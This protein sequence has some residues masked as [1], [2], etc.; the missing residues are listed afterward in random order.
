[1]EAKAE[2]SDSDE[3]YK[4]LNKWH[5]AWVSDPLFTSSGDRYTFHSAGENFIALRAPGW[6]L[7]LNKND[8][9]K[10][11]RTISFR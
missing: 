2:A 5:K 3:D 7:F 6:I 9:G 4:E 11:R 1:L 10:V 8:K